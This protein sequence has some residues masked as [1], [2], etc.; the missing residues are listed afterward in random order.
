MSRLDDVG[1][2]PYGRAPHTCTTVDKV[3]AV[4]DAE[5]RRLTDE[6]F[7]RCHRPGVD[8]ETRR[9]AIDQVVLSNVGV[10]RGLAAAHRDKGV[11]REDLDQVAY[12][13][14]VAAAQRF[15]PGEGRDF[16]SFAVPTIRGELKRHFRDYGWTVRPPRRVQEIHLQVLTARDALAQRLDRAPTPH[17]IASELGESDLHVAEALRLDGC[18]AP[19][20]L[21]QA[22]GSGDW[23]LG[24]L[25]PEAGEHV[26]D[27]ADA[28]VMLG[29][30]IRRL[31]RRDRDVLRMRFFEGLTQQEIGERL[32]VTQ[33]QVSRILT[34]I[35]GELRKSVTRE[36]DMET[37]LAG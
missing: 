17:E 13:A 21:D 33:T 36:E 27:A 23:T 8:A 7:A 34:R 29:P 10:A 32:G 28:R 35:T 5:R 9:Q 6:A 11:P 12:T 16:L 18:F 14:L 4:D 37:A 30:A 2:A 25:L 31:G 1:R 24:D 20:S 19:S 22:V 3:S 15:R 26:Y